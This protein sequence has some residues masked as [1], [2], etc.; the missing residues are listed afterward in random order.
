MEETIP[1]V[2]LDSAEIV[3]IYHSDDIDTK[4]VQ[5]ASTLFQQSRPHLEVE[6][7]SVGDF[8]SGIIISIE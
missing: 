2:H 6:T 5:A 3:T 8:G 4:L 1:K 7:I